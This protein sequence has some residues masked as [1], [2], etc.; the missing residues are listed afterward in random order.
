MATTVGPSGGVSNMSTRINHPSQPLDWK[1]STVS[2]V[3]NRQALLQ[4][5]IT[6]ITLACAL[7]FNM[8]EPIHKNTIWDERETDKMMEYL[9]DNTAS[10]GDGGNFKDSTYQ[11]AATYI[12]PYHKSG[13]IKTAKHVKGKYKSVSIHY[14]NI[15]VLLI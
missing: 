7:I 15:F 8:S 5:V 10:A 6:A 3:H 14:F 9:G 11:A 2:S 13:P 4:A 12:A 1:I